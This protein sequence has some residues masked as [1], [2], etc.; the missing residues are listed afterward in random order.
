ML[1]DDARKI[2][3][4]EDEGPH[5]K[6]GDTMPCPTSAPVSGVH[7]RFPEQIP[8][9]AFES[10]TPPPSLHLAHQITKLEAD[11]EAAKYLNGILAMTVHDVNNALAGMTGLAF[12]LE[13]ILQ[14]LPPNIS[15]ELAAILQDVEDATSRCATLG[16]QSLSLN[17][18]ITTA[19]FP[20]SKRPHPPVTLIENC[21]HR[22]SP[23]YKI[24]D[25]DQISAIMVD[26]IH[27]PRV[28]VNLVQN[29]QTH[30]KSGKN[31]IEIYIMETQDSHVIEVKD[32][33]KGLPTDYEK[34]F[35]YGVQG[36]KS[37]SSGYGIGLSACRLITEAHGGEI[38]AINNSDGPGATFRVIIPKD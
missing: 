32:R 1:I 20:I 4:S 8:V 30:G 2:G 19:E 27:F 36:N 28:I 13:I 9:R 16:H 22:L 6:E 31:P 26:P 25:P 37:P 17:R 7:S 24:Y 38:M 15:P 18:S 10:T 21:I 5:I 3:E 34:L 23:N 14:K 29:A 33:G 12:E 11:L 35:D